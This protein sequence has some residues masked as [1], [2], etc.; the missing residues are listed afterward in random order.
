MGGSVD[1]V[2]NRE[3]DTVEA[4]QSKTKDSFHGNVTVGMMNP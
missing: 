3:E 1:L 2:Y 4:A